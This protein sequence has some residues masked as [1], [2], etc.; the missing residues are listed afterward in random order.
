MAEQTL[1]EWRVSWLMWP[2]G[3]PKPH[4]QERVT[5]DEAGARDQMEGLMTMVA[6][7]G[8]RPCGNHIWDPMLECR[9][10]APSEW[11]TVD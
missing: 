4:R 5:T 3:D 9:S 10:V 7:H 6:P 8:V 11:T 1:I 2:P